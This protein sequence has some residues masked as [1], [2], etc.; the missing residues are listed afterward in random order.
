MKCNQCGTDFEGKFCQNCGVPAPSTDQ[1]QPE[2]NNTQAQQSTPIYTQPVMQQPVQKPKKPIFKKWWFWVIIAVVVIGVIGN[3]GGNSNKT[4][5]GSSNTNSTVSTSQN[6]DSSKNDTIANE[7][8]KITVADFS[9]MDQASIQSWADTN[10]V[11][12]KFSE[13]YSDS[14]AKGS[15]VSQSKNAGETVK[16]GTTIKVVIS[17]GKKPSVE[18]LN[19]LAKAEMYSKT[20]YMSKKG[21]Y[22]QLTSDYGEKF[23]ADAAQYAIDNMSADWNAN[24][25]QKA[26]TYQKTMSMS[27]S[28]IYD[29]LISEYGEK[30]TKDEAQY[31][32]G[33]LD[34]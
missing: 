33:H 22:D 31:A 27:K 14:V 12:C 29:Q 21:I 18:Y 16:E 24:A 23:P 20:M 28:A 32:I 7:E 4:D 25:L 1:T 5:S 9:G 17:R 2:V 6:S 3:L 10:K 11:T 15:V 30:F 34:D 8:A 26:K 13:D 19:A